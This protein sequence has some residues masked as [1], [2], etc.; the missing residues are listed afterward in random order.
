MLTFD[1][2]SHTYRW[3]GEVRPSVTQ[4]LDKLHSF[5]NVPM[6]VLNTAKK[7]GSTVHMLTQLNDEKDLVEDSVEPAFAGYLEA[8]RKFCTEHSPEWLAIEEAVYSEIWGVAG[9]PDRYATITYE[10]RRLLAQIDIKTSAASHP[11]WGVQ[12]SAY[13]HLSG[14]KEALR[15]TCQLRANGTY[16][17]TP[18]KDPNDWPVFL[19]LINLSNWTK[20]H[21]I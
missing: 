10:G 14:H 3:R 9:T 19:S 1:E 7:R 20:K 13:N 18:W 16:K 11:C 6:E 5:A 2:A 8:W 4:V 17:L 12:L 15:L 21:A